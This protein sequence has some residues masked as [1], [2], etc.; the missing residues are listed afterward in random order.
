M[1]RFERVSTNSRIDC[2]KYLHG[3][4]P[5]QAKQLVN[6]VLTASKEYASL[7]CMYGLIGLSR[8]FSKRKSQGN[9]HCC[10]STPWSTDTTKMSRS[11]FLHPTIVPCFLLRG[12]SDGQKTLKSPLPASMISL[13]APSERASAPELFSCRYAVNGGSRMLESESRSY[14]ENSWR[15]YNYLSSLA[16]RNTLKGQDKEEKKY[17]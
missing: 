17:G 15:G 5:T 12:A 3:R 9:I 4:V 10:T 1:V 11:E 16:C 8:V 14:M 13:L 6:R 7:K 2:S